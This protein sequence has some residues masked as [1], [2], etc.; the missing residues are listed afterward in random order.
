[1]ARDHHKLR[2]FDIAD[3]L[4]VDVYQITTQLPPEERYGLQSQVRRA[5]VS[6]AVNIVEGCARRTTRDYVHFMSIALGSASEAR[7]LLELAVRLTFI[8]AAAHAPLD[9]RFR[10]LIRS[11]NKL[12]ES[13]ADRRA[14]AAAHVVPTA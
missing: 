13:L 1:M 4:V 12:V 11:L 5:T 10:E 6:A 3:A 8:D 9:G 2:V 14:P 7:Y